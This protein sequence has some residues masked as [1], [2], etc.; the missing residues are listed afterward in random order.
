MLKGLFADKSL[1]AQLLLLFFLAFMGTLFFTAIGLAITAGIYNVSTEEAFAIIS[2]LNNAAGK[3]SFKIIQGLSTIGTFLVPAILGA[4]MLSHHPE[5]FMGLSAIPKPAYL[6]L[7]LVAAST[8]GLGA[9]SDVLYRFSESFPWPE[10]MIEGFKSSQE[11][12]MQ[13]YQALLDMNSPLQFAQIFLL[14]AVLP[15][16]AEEALFRGTLQPLLQR[17]L[18]PHVAIWITAFM[19]SILHMQYLTFLSI[20]VLGALLGY[21]RYWT[22]SIWLPTLLHLV[23]NGSIVIAVYFFGVDYE[24]NLSATESLPI[25]ESSISIAISV[26]CLLILER[27]S[28]SLRLD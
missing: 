5:K 28:R 26:V 15:A 24:E 2:N 21:L 13:Q 18:N 4:H 6:Y 1:G 25:W 12:M 11:L 16:V 27:I 20:L 9:A 8:Y 3:E 7:V 10:V 19:F 22:N 23:N 17:Y 14:M